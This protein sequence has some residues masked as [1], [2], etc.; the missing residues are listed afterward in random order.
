MIGEFS[1]RRQTWPPG[2]DCARRGVIDRG[3]RNLVT[4]GSPR[5]VAAALEFPPKAGS[6]RPSGLRG[7][8]EDAER[9][10][11]AMTAA[12]DGRTEKEEETSETGRSG[13]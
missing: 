13:R 2:V 5:A 6:R 12:V 11:A 9:G 8:V 7:A 3:N 10:R 1:F 4:E